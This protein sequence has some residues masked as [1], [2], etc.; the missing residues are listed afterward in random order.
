[1]IARST[2]FEMVDAGSSTES[3]GTG[4]ADLGE[5][6]YAVVVA[7]L[8]TQMPLQWSQSAGSTSRPAAHSAI[9]APAMAPRRGAEMSG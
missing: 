9:N 6:A 8:T 5:T 3:V 4:I 2:S 7:V 1:M